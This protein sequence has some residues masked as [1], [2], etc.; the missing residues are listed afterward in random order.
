MNFGY[1]I[2]VY[3]I[4]VL[5]WM[6]I[7]SVK[8]RLLVKKQAVSVTL[9]WLLVIY[10]L[11]L[12]GVIAYLLFG[13]IKLGTRRAKAFQL[14]K[15]KYTQW[16]Q[17]LSEQKDLVTHSQDPRY[18]TLFK[19]V[20]QRLGIPNIRGNELHLLDTPESIIRSIISDIQQARYSINMV[21]YIWSNDGLINEVKQALEEAVQRGVR[22]CLLLDSVGSHAFLKSS[23]CKEMRAKGIEITEALHVNLFRMFFNRIDLRQHRK[24]IV[25]DNQ[26]AYTGSMNMVDPILFKQESNVGNWVDIMVRINGPVSPILNSLHAWDWEIETMEELPL[27]LPNCPI[28]EIDDNDTHSVQVIASGPA[29]PDDLI[30]QSLAT[31]IYAAREN[32]V[33]TTPYFVPSHN[34]AEALRIAAFS[35]VDITLILPKKNDSLMVYW[36]SRTFFDDLLEAGVKIYLFDAGLLHTKSVLI[37]NKLAL[38]GTVNMDLRSF[39]LN[40]E[41]TIAVEDR[42]FANEVAMLHENYL[43]NSSALNMQEWINR[44]FYHRIIERLFFFFSPLL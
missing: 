31:A 15:P 7:I 4:P 35:G 5:I 43:A 27:L 29:F 36:A 41:I 10:L 30:A 33:I 28:V 11:P 14:L 13:E 42:N 32:I 6:A 25:I 37:D 16:F 22:V 44:P 20:H 18:R 8:L 24:I 21:F 34:I 9:S 2:L 39:L 12:I 38:I 17:Q 40:F 1:I 26:I 3:I 19:L 23:I